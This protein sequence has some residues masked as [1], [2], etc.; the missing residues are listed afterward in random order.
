MTTQELRNKIEQVLGNNLRCLLPSYWWKN[1]FHSVADRID[2]V[3]QK[4]DDIGIPK[5]AS[6]SS[7]LFITPLKEGEELSAESKKTNAASYRKVVNGFAKNEFYDVKIFSLFMV[8]EATVISNPQVTHGVLKLMYEFDSKTIV[9][10]V[11]ADGSATLE[12]TDNSSEDI[13]IDSEL[14]D[15]SENPVQNK[16]IK[17]YV[18]EKVANGG[19]LEI[20]EFYTGESLTAEQKAWNLETFQLFQENKCFIVLDTGSGLLPLSLH[21]G[22]SFVFQYGMINTVTINYEITVSEDGSTTTRNVNDLPDAELSTTSSN[23]V[24]NRV[25]TAALNNKVDKVNGK[26]L[27]TE[28]FTSALKTK[29]EGLSN[30]DDTSIQNAV[31]SLTTQINTLVSGDASAAI[32]SFNEIVAFLNGVED[33]EN[34]DSIIAAIEQQ[35][36]GKQDTISD[37]AT[38]RSGAALGA[39]AIQS[40]KTINGQSIVGSGNVVISVDTSNLVTKEEFEDLTNEIL[41]NEEVVAA[42]FNDINERINAI[43]ENVSGTTVTKE[44]LESAVET[45]NQTISDNKSATDTAIEG[46]ETSIGNVDAKF[47]NY[48]TTEALTTEI[49]NLTNEIIANEEVHAAAL[50]DLNERLNNA[51]GGSSGGSGVVTFYIPSGETATDEE[52]AKNKAAYEAY[53]ASYTNP[54]MVRLGYLDFPTF[55]PA[56]M[57]SYDIESNRVAVGIIHQADVI[58]QTVYA[59]ESDGSV[60]ML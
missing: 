39:T 5:P 43:S 22:R 55:I 18:D 38:I 40:V 36:A 37:L 9:L 26:Q 52:I 13:T 59:I 21:A 20:R 47:A 32:E 17:A 50:N 34:L 28:D 51:G 45:I 11:L 10:S 56:A 30:Y 60:T 4:V 27:S 42:A 3:E 24:T 44:E 29:L 7:V 46:L 54:P 14:S 12:E 19:G 53:V 6:A 49:T 33:S 23:V 48:A 15:T 16:V 41:D 2:E 35:I 31:N 58:R 25:I 57:S 8:V 1:L